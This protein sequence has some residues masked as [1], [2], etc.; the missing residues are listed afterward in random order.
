[1]IDLGL[2]KVALT[3]TDE[4]IVFDEIQK[5]QRGFL[6]LYGA[7]LALTRFSEGLGLKV[8][9]LN[10]ISKTVVKEDFYGFI[11]AG[12]NILRTLDDNNILKGKKYLEY[13]VKHNI[14]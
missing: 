13:L 4:G 12:Q 5:T 3:I 7:E 14:I 10:E 1:M 2:T 8:K 9:E 11:N 6:S